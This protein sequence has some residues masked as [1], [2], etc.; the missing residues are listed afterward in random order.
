MKKLNEI[1]CGLLFCLVLILVPL[2]SQAE[3]KLPYPETYVPSAQEKQIKAVFDDPRDLFV[4]KTYKD[5]V[6][7]EVYNR[8]T[9]DQEKMKKEWAE[10]RGFTALELVG[11]IA[12][13]IKSGKYIQRCPG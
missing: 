10:L 4:E 2:A 7:P 1:K 6:P 3:E 9:F 5:I 13:E 12:P 8:I 11:K